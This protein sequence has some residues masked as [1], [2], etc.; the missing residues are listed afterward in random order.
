MNKV[1][2]EERLYGLL[3]AAKVPVRYLNYDELLRARFEF[4]W[5]QGGVQNVV[6]GNVLGLH[7]DANEMFLDLAVS[8]RWLV[9]REII[10]LHLDQD[11]K[12]C[13]GIQDSDGYEA[14]PGTLT[15]R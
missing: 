7:F 11:G 10:A 4:S 3:G 15:L 6:I 5:L 12:C 14:F 2:W 13:I 9:S 8:V 1:D